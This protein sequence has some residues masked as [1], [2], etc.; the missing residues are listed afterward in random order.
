MIG[1]N[2]VSGTINLTILRKFNVTFFINEREGIPE[3]YREGRSS[4]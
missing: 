1:A 4:S 2:S 3:K